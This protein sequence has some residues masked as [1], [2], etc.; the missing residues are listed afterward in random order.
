MKTAYKPLTFFTLSLILPWALW[1]IVAYWSHQPISPSHWLL[2]QQ[3]YLCAIRHC[4][5]TSISGSLVR[6]CSAI[7]IFG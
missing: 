7:G 5:Q 1:F 6:V 3:S 4:L 2:W